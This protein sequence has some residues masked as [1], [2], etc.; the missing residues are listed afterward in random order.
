VKALSTILKRVSDVKILHADTTTQQILPQGPELSKF[1]QLEKL[2]IHDSGPKAWNYL[3]GASE[4]TSNNFNSIKLYE[5]DY[6]AILDLE[7]M[8]N[9]NGN[10]FQRQGLGTIF[11]NTDLDYRPEIKI[12]YPG[13]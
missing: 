13:I 10:F 4:V 11:D 3:I 12:I 9:N 1:T 6:V 8:I 2:I 5:S 7:W